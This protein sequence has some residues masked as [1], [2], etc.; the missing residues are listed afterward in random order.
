M[1]YTAIERKLFFFCFVII[2]YDILTYTVPKT[3][4]A[5]L[6]D[7]WFDLMS[8]VT[9]YLV[10]GL[11]YRTDNHYLHQNILKGFLKRNF[12]ITL[13]GG[14][15]AKLW[16]S[17]LIWIT[18]LA[19]IKR[20]WIEK[21][22]GILSGSPLSARIKNGLSNVGAQ[23]RWIHGKIR[24]KKVNYQNEMRWLKWTILVLLPCSNNSVAPLL[25]IPWFI[26]TRKG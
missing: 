16:C 8:L 13:V 20:P 1:D 24:K 11:R 15:K 26:L 9:S 4:R 3:R 10:Q 7:I 14:W 5:V 6:L 22:T 21:L 19:T 25:V 23:L 17:R 12:S 2:F 18:H